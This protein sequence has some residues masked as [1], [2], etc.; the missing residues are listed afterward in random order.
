MVPWWLSTDLPDISADIDH[1][2]TWLV[3][4]ERSF[5][6]LSRAV[7]TVEIVEELVKVGLNEVC[8]IISIVSIVLK[9]SQENLLNSSQCVLTWSVSTELS[10]N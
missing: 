6:G 1:L 10:G 3:S 9:S 5:Q 4:I 8:D 2:E 7:E